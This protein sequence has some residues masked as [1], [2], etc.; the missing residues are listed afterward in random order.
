MGGEGENVA[1]V[2]K[3]KVRLLPGYTPTEK[4]LLALLGLVVVATVVLAIV[5]H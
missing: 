4:R 5:R 3:F 1:E 2:K